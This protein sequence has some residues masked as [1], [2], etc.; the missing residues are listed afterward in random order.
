MKASDQETFERAKA[1]IHEVDGAD[2]W[3]ENVAMKV[4]PG[5]HHVEIT[6]EIHWA[7]DTT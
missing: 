7:E 1:L 4:Y 5:L 3:P 6:F 2:L